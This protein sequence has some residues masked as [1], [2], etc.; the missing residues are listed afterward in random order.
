MTKCLLILYA[1]QTGRTE[2]LA[3]ACHEGALRCEGVTVHV[4][5]AA[6][7]SLED[8]L[9]ADGVLIGT[10]SNFGY[11]AGAVK[12]FF[13]RTFYPAQGRVEGLPYGLFV[14]AGNDGRGAVASVE[15]IARGYPFKPVCPPLI[16]H[17]E[18]DEAALAAAQEMGETLATGILMGMF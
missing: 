18:P 11:M 12:D 6:A 15:R 4:R 14:S 7:A 5:R 9:A 16:V 13:D 3:E 8:L 10:P 1:S 17:G 2:R